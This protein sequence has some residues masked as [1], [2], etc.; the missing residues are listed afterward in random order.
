VKENKVQSDVIKRLYEE[1][2]TALI[3]KNDPKYMQGI[4]DLLLL[5]EDFWAAL[6][7]KRSPDEATQPNQEYYVN[8]MANMSFAA[9]VDPY[10]LESVINA[11]Q[12]ALANRRQ[13]RIFES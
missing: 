13:A 6:E 11:I 9:F 4:P 2:P 1:F 3:L 10:N 8:R 5:V 7:I 12:Q